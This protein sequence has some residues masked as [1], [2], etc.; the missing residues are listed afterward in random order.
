MINWDGKPVAN[1]H[2]MFYSETL[3]RVFATTDTPGAFDLG[4]PLHGE[5]VS[6]G[7]DWVQAQS[8]EETIESESG[9]SVSIPIVYGANG[10]EVIAIS[11]EGET[12][13]MFELKSRPKSGG[14]VSEKSTA[15]A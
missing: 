13:L 11:N 8:T 7:S 1:A 2:L 14:Y 12:T 3:L 5:G 10:I 6:A 9:K 15:E 4:N